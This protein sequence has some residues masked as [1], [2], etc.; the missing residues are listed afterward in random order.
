MPIIDGGYSLQYSPLME[1][2]E[3]KGMVLFCQLDVTGRTESDPAAE[4]L[5][6]NILR[7]VSGWKAAERNRKA[8]Y[9]GDPAG[10]RHLRHA[11]I[12]PASYD[13]GQLSPDEVLIVGTGGGKK[14]AGNAQAVGEFVK[15]GGNVLALGLEEAEAN[16]FLPAAVQMKKQEHIA[17]FFEP[18]GADSLLAGIGPADAHNRGEGQLPLLSGGATIFGDGSLAKVQDANVVFWQQPPYAITS[19]EGAVA[20]FQVDSG[21]APDGKNSALVVMGTTTEAGGQLIQRITAGRVAQ[22]ATGERPARRAAGARRGRFAGRRGPRTAEWTPQV[23]TLYTFAVLIKGVGAPVTVHLEVQRASDP[24]DRAAKGPDVVVPAGEWT[25]LHVSFKCENPFPEGLQ[26]CVS[27]AQDG[28][29]YRADMLRFYE[30]DYVPLKPQS[31]AAAQG[32]AAPVN[33]IVNPSF[34]SGS[35]PYV[36]DF[37]EQYNLRRTYRRSSYL[38]TRA[39]A[40]MGVVCPTPLLGRFSSPVLPDKPEK[41]WAEGLYVDQPEAWDDPYR[42]FCW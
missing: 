35:Q 40:N 22:R 36:F 12:V 9:V 6:G 23:G 19:A 34:A 38:L 10:E 28:G 13:G 26:A 17:S 39:L 3:G 21:D 30:G 4:T 41:R 14:L 5:V 32:A 18:F 8:L 15:A 2:R 24:Y 27:C 11:G 7:Y 33:L 16:S 37:I 1:Y 20:S 31:E 25:D 29:C 42:W